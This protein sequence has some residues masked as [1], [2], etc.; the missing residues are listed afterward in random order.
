MSFLINPFRAP[1]PPTAIVVTWRAGFEGGVVPENT[2]AGA[3][4]ADLTTMGG[5]APVS[6]AEIADADG[7]FSVV[8]ATIQLGA[9]LDYETKTLH[10]ATLRATDADGL[11]L[12]EDVSIIVGDIS[13]GGVPADAASALVSL[14]VATWT[15]SVG[16]ATQQVTWLNDINDPGDWHSPTV[17]PKRITVPVDGVYR[18]VFNSSTSEV[19]DLH[20]WKNGATFAGGASQPAD[21]STGFEYTNVASAFVSVLAGDY[22]T[23]RTDG[24]S[25][26]FNDSGSW[27]GVE[28]LPSGWAYALATKSA[29][30]ALAAGTTTAV[31]WGAETVDAGGRH[32][33]ASNTDRLTTISGDAYARVSASLRIDN[34]ALTSQS[35]LSAQKNGA[36][37]RGM[38]AKDHEGDQATAYISAVS[39]IVPVTGGTDYFTA[40]AFTTDATDLP[41]DNE[42]WFQIEIVP[43]THKFATIYPTSNTSLSAGVWTT[44]NMGGELADTASAYTS[45]NTMTVPAGMNQMRASFNIKTPSTAGQIMGRVARNGAYENGLPQDDTDTAGTDNINGFGMWIACSPGD[46]VRLEAL[47]ENAQTL[48]TDNETWLCVEFRNGDNSGGGS[49]AAA[50][51]HSMWVGALS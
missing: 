41:A 49:A 2:A 36:A 20:L 29:T 15:S 3:V 18:A 51:L 33:T 1:T 4:L 17:N 7:K 44:V 48:G 47:S 43:A 42:S 45:G 30:Q 12:D 11:T 14:G 37:F 10:T 50:E 22:F 13:E 8:G 34:K 5:R 27:F 32:S 21:S 23:V 31:V 16:S 25:M 26:D 39:A 24:T 35:V 9:T 28:K 38:F 6:F 19:N 46:T 40:H